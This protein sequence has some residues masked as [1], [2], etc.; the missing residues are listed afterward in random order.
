MTKVDV[1]KFA[2]CTPGPWEFDREYVWADAIKGYVADPNTEDM[3]RRAGALRTEHELQANGYLIAA[4][5]DLLAEVIELRAELSAL[6]DDGVLCSQTY[7]AG[8]CDARDAAKTELAAEKARVALLERAV[9]RKDASLLEIEN[10][11]HA[12]IISACITEGPNIRESALLRRTIAA[13][14]YTGQTPP[15]TTGDAT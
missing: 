14:A 3:E 15:E 6:R 9:V 2:G 7:L 4:A 1:S 12:F 11:L 8:I 13:R 5:P 10:Y